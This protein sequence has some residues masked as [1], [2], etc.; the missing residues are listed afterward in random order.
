MM[1]F[2]HG[3]CK[4]AAT[5]VVNVDDADIDI[6]DVDSLVSKTLL[7]KHLLDEV[8][9]PVIVLSLQDFVQEGIFYLQKPVKASDMLRVLGQAKTLIYERSKNTTPIGMPTATTTPKIVALATQQQGLESEIT[10]LKAFV[11]NY[12][13]S[14][15]I[16]KNKALNRQ[17][18]KGFNEYIDALEDL[19]VNDPKQIA[20]ANYNPN[21]FYQ[22]AI[23]SALADC[24]AKKKIF[25]LESDWQPIIIFPRTSELWVDAGDEELKAFAGVK[26]KYKTMT[27]KL[28]V[29]PVDPETINMGIS[30]SNFQSME[31]FLWKLACWT[32]LGRYPKDI[33]YTKPVYLKNWPNF[34]R[35]LITPHALR[36]AA[37]LTKG[38]KTM[39]NIA[40]TLQIK[41]QYVFVFISAAYAI[42]LAGQSRRV[43]DVLVEEL[44]KQRS[45]SDVFLLGR[46]TNKLR[47]NKK[48]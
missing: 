11:D 37:L 40:Q 43:S 22:G 48:V 9:K 13:K 47:S 41:P 8:T 3:P 46:I 27:A 6:F 20:I 29:T 18:E 21:D 25:L 35:L 4:D 36:I 19:D 34:T 15:K 7:E 23:Q 2:L 1:L 39:V 31:S 24:Q 16:L 12:D 42:G 14:K 28:K 32:S 5:V 17:D 45:Y 44:T 38:P 33:D 26:M 30:L 10:E